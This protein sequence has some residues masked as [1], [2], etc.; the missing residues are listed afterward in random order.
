MNWRYRPSPDPH[1]AV[2]GLPPAT[3][4]RFSPGYA[5]E[6][7]P[8]LTASAAPPRLCPTQHEAPQ[9]GLPLHTD[10]QEQPV[11]SIAPEAVKPQ[12]SGASGAIASAVDM[13]DST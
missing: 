4:N 3:S 8:S 7:S 11:V 6:T 12:E 2:P 10:H 9:R 1:R 13:A 5:A